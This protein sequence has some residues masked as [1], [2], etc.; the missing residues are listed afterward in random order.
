[1][2]RGGI[3]LNL[4]AKHGVLKSTSPVLYASVCRQ[5]VWL[6]MVNQLTLAVHAVSQIDHAAI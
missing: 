2:E 1:M 4:T 3:L 6:K 5:L